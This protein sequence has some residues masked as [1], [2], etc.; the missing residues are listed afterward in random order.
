MVG[1]PGIDDRDPPARHE[2]SAPRHRLTPDQALSGERSRPAGSRTFRLRRAGLGRRRETI[3][4]NSTLTPTRA[5]W[6]PRPRRCP[7]GAIS[8]LPP[9]P[10][11]R[12]SWPT[13]A[14]RPIPLRCARRRPCSAGATPVLPSGDRWAPWFASRG[15]GAETAL[16]LIAVRRSWAERN[17]STMMRKRGC[18]RGSDQRSLAEGDEQLAARTS[19]VGA[20]EPLRSPCQ[21]PSRP[22]KQ[23]HA[24]VRLGPAFGD[25]LEDERV[26][27][28]QAGCAP[29]SGA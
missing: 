15:L 24:R 20:N 6:N 9:R 3:V 8:N 11:L 4:A 28:A 27:C 16:T 2:R 12:G 21:P 25:T 14:E 22:V 23:S 10:G 18:V 7:R 26:R 5:P 1:P 17:R 13:R 19:L 29:T